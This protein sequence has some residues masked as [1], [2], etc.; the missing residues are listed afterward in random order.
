MVES[1][2]IPKGGDNFDIGC[3]NEFG[4]GGE[5][6]VDNDVE[7]VNNVVESF[8]LNATSL[9]GNGFK[10]W[11]KDFMGAILEIMKKKEVPVEDRKAFKARAANIAKFFLS[12]FKEIEF[13]LGP[14]F[15]PESMVFSMY[16]EG[17]HYPNFYYIM[18]GLKEEKF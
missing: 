17:A 14:S 7:M 1:K 6:E 10:S 3:G 9:D 18:D 12:N 11:L 16:P 13:Y 4:G 2:N 8:N 15:N 5:E